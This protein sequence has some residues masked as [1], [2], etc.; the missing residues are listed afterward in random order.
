MDFLKNY[1]FIII[2]VL[3]AIILIVMYFMS[4]ELNKNKNKINMLESD[5]NSIR[6]RLQSVSQ[7]VNSIDLP[8]SCP[9]SSSSINLADPRLS[10]ILKFQDSL[11]R[12]GARSDTTTDEDEDEK[13]F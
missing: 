10:D 8:A 12:G 3:L 13:Y 5:L 7:K 4:N 2:G 6:E 9:V 1:L 11:F